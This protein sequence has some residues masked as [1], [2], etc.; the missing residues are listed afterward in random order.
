MIQYQ[1][2]EQ[3]YTVNFRPNLFYI[4]FVIL[5]PKNN[6]I[7]WSKSNVN[8]IFYHLPLELGPKDTL[9]IPITTPN[10]ILPLSLWYL[11]FGTPIDGKRIKEKKKLNRRKKIEM[12]ANENDADMLDW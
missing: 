8:S 9:H 3:R 2:A 1:G 11:E 5:G 6:Y 12:V 4:S 7:K 10:I